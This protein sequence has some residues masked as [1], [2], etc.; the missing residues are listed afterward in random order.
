MYYSSVQT[1]YSIITLRFRLYGV[2]F[3]SY[4]WSLLYHVL[5]CNN[6]YCTVILSIVLQYPVLYYNTGYCN[7]ILSTVM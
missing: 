2:Y 1:G 4:P 7:M 5:Y 3:V 6:Q